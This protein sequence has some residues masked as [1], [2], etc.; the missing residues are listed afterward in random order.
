MK[1]AIVCAA[2]LVILAVVFLAWLR[3][4]SNISYLDPA[5]PV[6]TQKL[7]ISAQDWRAIQQLVP[8]EKGLVVMDV[9]RVTLNI[10]DVRF[11]KSDDH[12]NSQAGPFYR[13]EKRDGVWREQTNFHGSWAV[14]TRNE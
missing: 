8:K 11:K 1:T 12:S 6:L 10:I 7:G 5:D 4:G 13:Y 3:R 2:S 14:I 9:G